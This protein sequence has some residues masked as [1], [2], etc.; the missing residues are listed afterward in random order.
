MRGHL[1]GHHLIDVNVFICN[2][3][4]IIGMGNF[5]YELQNGIDSD[6]P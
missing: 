5:M 4:K 3:I 6:L 2:C 1:K